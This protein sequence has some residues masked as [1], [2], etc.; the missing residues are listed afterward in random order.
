MFMSATALERT[1]QATVD[2][3]EVSRKAGEMALAAGAVIGARMGVL[4]GAQNDPLN[5]DHAELGRMVTEKMR[6]FSEAGV[7]ILAEYWSLQ[8]DVGNYVL[9][10]GQTMMVGRLPL[11]GEL[12]ELT[13][14]TSIH[15][16]RLATSAIGAAAVGLA[17][18][19]KKAMS[20]ARHLARRR[21]RA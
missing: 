8:R 16:T 7:A 1:M 15:T 14:R 6:A 12:V 19:H 13:E 20:N 5:A 9:F 11:P 4:A 10:L 3:A 21:R 18:L 17:P 2:L